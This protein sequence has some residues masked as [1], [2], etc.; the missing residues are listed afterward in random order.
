MIKGQIRY[1]ATE[2]I[3]REK[4]MFDVY[5]GAVVI[6]LSIAKRR[7]ENLRE[8]RKVFKWRLNMLAT[9]TM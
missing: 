7:R 3:K 1:Q 4:Q 6:V 2:H 5:A 9:A 8:K